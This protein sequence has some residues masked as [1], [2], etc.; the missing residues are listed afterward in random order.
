VVDERGGI[1]QGSSQD[2]LVVEGEQPAGPVGRHLPSQGALADLAGSLDDDDGGVLKGFFDE[3]LGA[4]GDRP[5][6]G[7]EGDTPHDADSRGFA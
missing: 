2:L 5:I 1:E 6:R 3:R 7:M 4:P